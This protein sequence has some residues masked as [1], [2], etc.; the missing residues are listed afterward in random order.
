MH[1]KNCS[2]ASNPLSKSTFKSS[3]LDHEG[4]ETLT[5]SHKEITFKQNRKYKRKYF[6]TFIGLSYLCLTP[7]GCKSESS[8][9]SELSDTN[10]P[11][12]QNKTPI[13]VRRARAVVYKVSKSVQPHKKAEFTTLGGNLSIVVKPQDMNNATYECDGETCT[14]TLIEPIIVNATIPTPLNVKLKVQYKK[15]RK[16]DEKLFSHRVFV[17]GQLTMVDFGDLLNVSAELGVSVVAEPKNGYKPRI[18]DFVCSKS[19]SCETPLFKL[20]G[21]IDRKGIE[22]GGQLFVS[23]RWTSSDK[24]IAN[25]IEQKTVLTFDQIVNNEW[26]QK[27]PLIPCKKDEDLDVLWIPPQSNPKKDKP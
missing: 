22:F 10:A 27:L 8:R 1:V 7:V 13:V 19:I 24:F 18:E 11:P 20:T 12:V 21:N 23:E 26:I 14:A 16:P 17:G 3:S 4:V 5:L 6:C 15:A 2:E 25:Q 9:T